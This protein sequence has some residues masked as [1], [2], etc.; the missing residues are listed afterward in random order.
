MHVAE[1]AAQDRRSVFEKKKIST[2]YKKVL[3]SCDK[4]RQTDKATVPMAFA[5]S[6]T[7]NRDDINIYNSAFIKKAP[8]SQVWDE[9]LF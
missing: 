7:T 6:Q 5:L 2:A 3:G 9:C 4:Q 1:K 8:A